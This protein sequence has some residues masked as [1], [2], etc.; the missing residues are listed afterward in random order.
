[1]DI[2]VPQGSIL[3]PLLFLIYVNDIALPL[4]NT[5][6]RLFADD[7]NVFVFHNDLNTLKQLAIKAL[8]VLTN[9]FKHNH[10]TVNLTKTCFCVFSNKPTREIQ[11][12]SFDGTTIYRV[13]ETKYLGVIIDDK[14]TWGSH[15]DY[16]NKK[17]AK[18]RY[19]FRTLAKYISSKQAKQLYYSFAH[20]HIQYAIEIHGTCTE[21]LRR[22]LQVSQ[23]H[24]LRT[25]YGVKT[26]HSATQLRNEMHIPSV[27]KL[28]QTQLL[29]FVFKQQ[30]QM[31]PSV[32]DN[33]YQTIGS[34]NQRSSRYSSDLFIDFRRTVHGC[35]S[36]KIVA[37]KLWNNLPLNV[38]HIANFNEF[39]REVTDYLNG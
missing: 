29:S 9:W 27:L 33:Y 32:F 39:R 8:S 16:V 21:T 14:L 5:E 19:V 12:L 1:M 13:H 17:L 35:K 7:T 28:F 23:N 15:I 38:R 22:T 18:L 30:H 3:G 10:L 11:S 37:A 36:T 26:R 34:I 25:L 24:I 2:G 31:L 6:I 20:P 4:E